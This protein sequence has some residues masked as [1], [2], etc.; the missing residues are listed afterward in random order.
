LVNGSPTKQFNI[1][2]GLRQGDPLSPFLFL[3]AA[4]GFNLLMKKAVE[5]GKFDGFRFDRGEDQFTHL[6]YADDTLI[7]GNKELVC[8]IG[9][10]LYRLL[11]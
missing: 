11:C 2:R 10:E 5:I 6:Q 3:L 1:G 9:S 7:I 8:L 4:E